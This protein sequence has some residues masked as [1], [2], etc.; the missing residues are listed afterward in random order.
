MLVNRLDILDILDKSIV[1]ITCYVGKR[2]KLLKTEYLC[3]Y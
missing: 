3:S 2:S 1:E